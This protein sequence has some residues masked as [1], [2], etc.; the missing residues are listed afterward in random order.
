MCQH[1]TLTE[2]LGLG[3]TLEVPWS[4]PPWKEGHPEPAEPRHP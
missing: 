3:G 4:K 2:W 1:R